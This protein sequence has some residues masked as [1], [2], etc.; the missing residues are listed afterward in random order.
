M[1]ALQ[2]AIGRAGSDG[3]IITVSMVNNMVMVNM[4]ELYG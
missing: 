4:E 3:M 1:L 2:E